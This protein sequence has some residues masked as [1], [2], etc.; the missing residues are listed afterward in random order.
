[1]GYLFD[2]DFDAETSDG[3]MAPCD[4]AAPIYT[5]DEL[6]AAEWAARAE[7]FEAGRAH[8]KTEAL[9]AAAAARAAERHDAL[10]TLAAQMQELC[11]GAV[12]H[13]TALETQMTEFAIVACERIVPE[14]LRT[15]STDRAAAEVR[16]CLGLIMGSTRI[17][18]FLSQ[19]ALEEHRGIIEET[20]RDRHAGVALELS[21]D[22]ALADGDARVEW[23]NGVMDYSFGQIAEQ[24]LDALRQTRPAPAK[25]TEK[26]RVAHG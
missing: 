6:H 11:A 21:S 15:R 16:R 24:L 25:T 9:E 19:R 22:P 3:F 2:R 23:D 5:E 1:M 12:D 7:G 17:R 14:I 10:V 26:G 13:R 8:G 20:V 4:T 18:V